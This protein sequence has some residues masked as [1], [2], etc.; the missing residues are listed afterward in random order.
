MTDRVQDRTA[1]DVTSPVEREHV[2][3]PREDTVLLARVARRC[4]GRTVLEIGVGSGAVA[5]AA[6]RAGARSVVATDLNP[7][8]LRATRRAAREG[9]LRVDV[10]R[11]DLARGL[12]RFE[13]I[14][15]NPP[16]LPTRA[17]ERDPDRWANLALDGGRHG[18]RVLARLLSTLP[19]HL[20]EAGRA[21]VVV[22]TAQD[23]GRLGKLRADWRARGGTLRV[24]Q[25]RRLEGER[26][27][28]WELRA[29]RASRAA[30]RT[31]RP[32]PGTPSRRRTPGSTRPGSSR[33]PA[34]GRTSARGAA[35]GRRRSPRGS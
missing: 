26:L 2:Y 16:Y 12:G 28:L 23:P 17:A 3:P 11:T 34:P 4:R 31:E 1:F 25:R 7:Y 8:A 18:C 33:G 35:S 21:Y 10:V 9:R 32:A 13:R 6:A 20:E 29:S 27:D 30:R 24:V 22:S 15:A 19:A 14:L 5:L